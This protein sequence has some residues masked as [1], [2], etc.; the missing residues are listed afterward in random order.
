[1]ADIKRLEFSLDNVIRDAPTKELKENAIITAVGSGLT[2]D[3]NYLK[4]AINIFE[5]LGFYIEAAETAVSLKEY[6][7]ASQLHN[8][9]E[10][11][12]MA[13][14]SYVK[15]MNEIKRSVR[16]FFK[17]YGITKLP[18]IAICPE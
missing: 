6:T 14:S 11:Q 8:Q 4:Q 15:K 10:S 18:R 1:M 12:V 17:K 5:K 16:T 3:P 2:E 7:K 9:Q 13:A